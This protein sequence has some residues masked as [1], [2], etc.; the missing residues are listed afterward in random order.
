[1]H[2]ASL[3]SSARGVKVIICPDEVLTFGYHVAVKEVRLRE[4]L[5]SGVEASTNSREQW[6]K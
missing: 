4:T 3:A 2:P 1:M 6:M 5:S